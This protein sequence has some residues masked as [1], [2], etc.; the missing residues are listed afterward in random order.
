MVPF[1][2]RTGSGERSWPS[3][4][5]N[6]QVENCNKNF[7]LITYG[8]FSKTLPAKEHD[9]EHALPEAEGVVQ[10]VVFAWHA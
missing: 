3:R 4:G 9:I 7:K 2:L 5:L 8:R 6:F 1:D 10:L